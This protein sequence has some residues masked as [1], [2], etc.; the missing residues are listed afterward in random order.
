MTRGLNEGYAYLFGYNILSEWK[1]TTRT[2][3]PTFSV[4]FESSRLEYL[5]ENGDT[6]KDGHS[7]T[8][9]VT[10]PAKLM[11]D[12][13]LTKSEIAQLYYNSLVMGRYNYNSTLNSVRVML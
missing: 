2:W 1:I 4:D 6:T 8:P 3:M 9:F 7:M 5:V 12:G 11:L 10:Y 13:G